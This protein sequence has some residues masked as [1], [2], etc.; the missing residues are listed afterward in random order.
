M[1]P[2]LTA[3]SNVTSHTS[4]WNRIANT[5]TSDNDESEVVHIDTEDF[6]DHMLRDIGIIDGRNV[7]GER[8]DRD[9]LSDLLRNDPKRFL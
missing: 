8:T 7:R 2:V 1:N 5:W 3:L 9:D 6:S 4:W